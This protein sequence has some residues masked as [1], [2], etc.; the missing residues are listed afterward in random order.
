MPQLKT[1]VYNALLDSPG[2]IATF[3]AL[4]GYS[5]P[6]LARGALC[7]L[8][9]VSAEEFGRMLKA[10]CT[11]R[12]FRH[13]ARFVRDG[14]DLLFEFPALRRLLDEERA[15]PKLDAPTISQRSKRFS[16]NRAEM[17]NLLNTHAE[18]WVRP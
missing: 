4:P 17:V 10:H 3:D 16:L 14:W 13:Q 6:A 1:H 15:A 18:I 9:Q 8:Y 5:Y 12:V 7:E 2:L 11:G